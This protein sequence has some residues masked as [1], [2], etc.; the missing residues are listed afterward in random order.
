MHFL[1]LQHRLAVGAKCYQFFSLVVLVYC[2][3]PGKTSTFSSPLIL[4]NC[5]HGCCSPACPIPTLKKVGARGIWRD[6]KWSQAV[7]PHAD[8][9]HPEV[10]GQIDCNEMESAFLYKTPCK[11]NSCSSV[12]HINP[13]FLFS[14]GYT[15]W[16]FIYKNLKH[17]R[18]VYFLVDLWLSGYWCWPKTSYLCI[19]SCTFANVKH[20]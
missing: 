20:S 2:P 15:P 3:I 18:F 4:S 17:F 19:G 5:L 16:C 7:E 11:H 6:S 10:W 1:G 9:R 14:T 8:I 12:W 13:S